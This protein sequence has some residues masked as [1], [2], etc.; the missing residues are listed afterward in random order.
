VSK[1]PN[2]EDFHEQNTNG[3]SDPIGLV[4]KSAIVSS[5]SNLLQMKKR[6]RSQIQLPTQG[7]SEKN[8][9][10]TAI[11]EANG[12]SSS[13]DVSSSRSALSHDNTPYPRDENFESKLL[14]PLP[15]GIH[16]CSVDEMLYSGYQSNTEMKELASLIT[17]DIF[18]QSPGNYNTFRVYT[19]RGVLGRHCWVG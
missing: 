9:P 5:K 2:K 1:I 17:R 13:H 15:L 7:S 4:G 19:I 12:A 6:M 10:N 16:C 3:A 8:N 11:T 14:K 18:L